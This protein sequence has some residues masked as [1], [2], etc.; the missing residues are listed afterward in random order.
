MLLRLPLKK[1]MSQ[2]ILEEVQVEATKIEGDKIWLNIVIKERPRLYKLEY[3]GIKKGEQETLS[4]KIKTYKGKIVTETVKKN[5]ELAIRKFYQDKG[6]LNVSIKIAEKTD[7]LRGNNATM[8]V[9]IKKGDKVKISKIE[10]VGR[11]EIK[12]SVLRRK[13]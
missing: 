10:F 7:S 13:L 6:Y 1:L 8:K 2:G 9:A 5:V 4:D 12:E 3:T 11:T